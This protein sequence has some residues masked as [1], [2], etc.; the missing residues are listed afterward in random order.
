MIRL[1]FF[2]LL[3]IVAFWVVSYRADEQEY[4]II[5]ERLRI[6]PPVWVSPIDDGSCGP[7]H[8]TR[9]SV[10]VSFQLPSVG[11]RTYHTGDHLMHVYLVDSEGQITTEVTEPFYYMSLQDG[12]AV[13]RTV[14][15]TVPHLPTPG[16]MTIHL[17]DDTRYGL[18]PP[19]PPQRLHGGF[20][21]E[22]AV[23]SHTFNANAL[24][25]DCPAQEGTLNLVNRV[26]GLGTSFSYA[27][28]GIGLVPFI[29]QPDD[30]GTF[31]KSFTNLRP[32]IY[33]INQA[34]LADYNLT[35]L[36]CTGDTDNG[37]QIDL[38]YRAVTIDLDAGENQTCTFFNTQL[39]QQASLS[40]ATSALGSHNATFGFDVAGDGLTPFNLEVEGNSFAKFKLAPGTYSVRESIPAGYKL[41]NLTCTGD[42]DN[43][44]SYDVGNRE[45]TIDL[46]PRETQTCTFE[47]TSPG[48]LTIENVVHGTERKSFDFRSIG[49]HAFTLAGSHGSRASNA[50]PNLPHGNYE[51]KQLPPPGYNLANLTCTGDTDDGNKI[52]LAGRSLIIDLDPGE[53]QVCSFTNEPAGARVR[54]SIIP[55]VS[56]AP[57]LWGGFGL[58]EHMSQSVFSVEILR[59]ATANADGIVGDVRLQ[60]YLVDSAGLVLSLWQENYSELRRD[61]QR[62]ALLY[63]F[64]PPSPGPMTVHLVDETRYVD[65]SPSPHIPIGKFFALRASTSLVFNAHVLNPNCP[66]HS[67]TLT[68][69]NT[70]VGPGTTI[71]FSTT[72]DGLSPF[73]LVL[74]DN[75]SANQLFNNLQPGTYTV[76][77]TELPGYPLTTLTCTGD[78]DDG[79]TRDL[80]N[81]KV[82]IDLDPGEDQTCSFFNSQ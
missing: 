76:T 74:T 1:C 16:P 64:E 58:C 35:N 14:V 42:I 6:I 32:T 72:G 69:S 54:M 4:P 70:V 63:I 55:P 20:F 28:T 31:N 23:A 13:Q 80:A 26:V 38:V 78:N 19:P 36:E 62:V 75:G 5:K 17:L 7:P 41:T 46:D 10:R 40:I 82:T 65:S 27:T 9:F 24:D 68:I 18:P 50:F 73:S 3:A 29:M 8:S 34:P 48:S 37:N 81:R 21:S 22:A 61:E 25:R 71:P 56:L 43:G 57:G 53:V 60:A 79:N 47:N 66:A 51:V 49:L 12:R 15:L 59:N 45:V 44:N 67:A 11:A 39:T 2:G 30:N 33:K 52:N 77:S